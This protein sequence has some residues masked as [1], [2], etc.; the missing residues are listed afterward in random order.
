MTSNTPKRPV[1]DP[2][3]SNDP[4]STIQPAKK[5]DRTTQQPS[6][7]PESVSSSL[8]T[9]M[10]TSPSV[11]MGTTGLLS[12]NMASTGPT[13]SQN[14]NEVT[15][16]TVYY[17]S[18]VV[19][20]Q[21]TTSTFTGEGPTQDAASYLESALLA[22]KGQRLKEHRQPVYIPPMA[23]VN[24][25]AKDED[26]FPL[27]NS[28]QDF[29][30][31]DRQV[32]LILGDSGAGK[33][34]FNRHLEHLLWTNY[35][36]GDPVP[37][38]INLPALDRPDLDMV[39]K[40]LK[41]YNFKD[42]QIQEMK[43]HC[44]LILI[45]DGY[46]ESQ[47]SA[48]LHTTNRLN[49]QDEWCAK[50]I[51]SCRTQFL[52]SVY[53]DRFVPQPT[54]RYKAVR[55]DLFQEAVIVPFSKEQVKDYVACYV[56]LEKRPWVTED[57]MRMLTTIP[58]L[59]D[60]V[61]NPFL[62]TLTLEALPGVTR[63]Q[64]ELSTIKLTRVQ[65]YD[66]FSN[67]WLGVNMR[68]LRDS[69]LTHDE[70]DILD[71]MWSN[72]DHRNTWRVDF[73]GPQPE[74]RFMRESS[75]LTRTGSLFRFI[76]RSMLEYFFSRA[77]F[78]PCNSTDYDE[79]APQQDSDSSIIQSLDSTGPLFKRNLV[80]EPSIIQFLSDRVKLNPS[81]EQQ[82]LCIINQSKTDASAAIAAA[83][84]ITILVRAGI[85]FNGVDLRNVKISGADISGGQFDCGRFQGADLKGVNL[86]KCWLREANF[87]RAQMKD[88]RFGEL[89]YL[90]TT[91][92]A[93]TCTYSPDG[94]FL[95]LVLDDGSISIYE[96]A[97]WSIFHSTYCNW[98]HGW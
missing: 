71:H 72:L 5:R 29:L 65:L 87:S 70:R 26:L 63:N 86:T 40:Q 6:T 36:N 78:D 13:A 18:L 35:N 8:N 41:V 82:L 14:R 44:Q 69:T 77:V 37:L 12:R 75:P 53:K 9:P 15:Q 4:Y 74:V 27:M 21:L 33:S 31:S 64:Q 67:E 42:G 10:P 98:K 3:E 56:P 61:K 79:F 84:A 46:D 1:S 16:Q 95:A 45:C 85:R 94:N 55:L 23:K 39:S 22:L 49:Q 50:M 80:G 2:D 73:F 30:D 92:G 96:A 43:Q 89:P 60:L 34:T 88:V 62:L 25:Q 68:R 90:N 17:K 57:Y 11:V 93:N 20:G 59:M 51:I 76:H 47:L 28:L 66:H 7:L 32:M 97:S 91:S 38:F 58:N 48:N 24:L 19:D 81:F 52:G 83:N 54:D